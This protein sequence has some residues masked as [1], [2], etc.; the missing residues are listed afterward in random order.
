MRIGRLDRINIPRPSA[1]G[2]WAVP[3]YVIGDISAND[4]NRSTRD[5]IFL[6]VPLSKAGFMQ[7]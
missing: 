4:A 7:G 2:E 1:A 5:H 6:V 3:I